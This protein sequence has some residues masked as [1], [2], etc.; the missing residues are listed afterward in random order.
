MN[1]TL[2]TPSDSGKRDEYVQRCIR[3]ADELYEQ[4]N[5]TDQPP[6][7]SARLRGKAEGLR[8]ALSYLLD[9]PT[10]EAQQLAIL[11]PVC[12]ALLQEAEALDITVDSDRG[13]GP[14]EE[15]DEITAARA[16]FAI[17]WPADFSED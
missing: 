4:A 10:I 9:Y 13:V 8:L 1:H 7:T 11:R 14:Y 16:A 17:V 15:S 3:A 6:T 2:P 12:M 5:A